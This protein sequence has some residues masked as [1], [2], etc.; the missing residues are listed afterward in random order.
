MKHIKPL[1]IIGISTSMLVG[2][3]TPSKPEQTHVMNV[4]KEYVEKPT[5]YV[6]D[7]TT[8]VL[9]DSDGFKKE[10]IE[11][12]IKHG[13]HWHVFT[14]DGKE[15]ITYK[16]PNKM[17]DSDE[18]SFV[19]VVTLDQL[20]DLDVNV[21]KKHG[22]HYHVYLKDGTEYLTYEN[23]EK[24]FPNIKIGEYVGSHSDST[25]TSNKQQTTIQ[26]GNEVVKIL[27]HGDH[28]HVYTASGD[29]YIT[30]QDPRDKYPNATFGQY[31]GTHASNGKHTSSDANK[32]DLID[33][34]SVGTD[35]IEE[36]VVKILKHD[37]HYH[38]Y[39]NTGKEYISYDD[40][41]SQ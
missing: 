37:D 4:P 10:D 31:T 33:V 14:K 29:E 22:D 27:Q 32:P 9:V 8:I 19:S 28:Y 38:I 3:S 26:K 20:K 35:Q 17:S 5:S 16:D 41:S 34:V 2:C 18:L 13:D 39:T 15:H 1:I 23:P 40:P 12:I 30:Y 24:L 21:I 11:K 7:D 6:E 25:N 36:K